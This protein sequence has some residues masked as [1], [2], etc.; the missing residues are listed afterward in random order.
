MID[1]SPD[2]RVRILRETAGDSFWLAVGS[3][4]DI[5]RKVKR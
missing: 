1:G 2:G 4:R 3:R 5:D